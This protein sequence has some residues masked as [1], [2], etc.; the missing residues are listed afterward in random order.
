MHSVIHLYPVAFFEMPRT[1]K[2]FNKNHLDWFLS[3]QP[4][5]GD[6]CHF[7][8]LLDGQTL[9]EQ[10]LGVISPTSKPILNLLA[11]CRASLWNTPNCRHQWRTYLCSGPGVLTAT[12]Y[13]LLEFALKLCIWSLKNSL[14]LLLNLFEY[15]NVA[16]T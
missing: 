3:L 15:N 4:S 11:W 12:V 1:L 2:S 5:R 16:C 14:H 6:R 7:L 10:R 13:S 9:L 8:W